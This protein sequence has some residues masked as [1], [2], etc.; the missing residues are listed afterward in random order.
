MSKRTQ[1][2]IV[3]LLIAVLL[4]G[5]AWPLVQE[6]LFQKRVN[7][8]APLLVARPTPVPA[9]DYKV[10]D[11]LHYVSPGGIFYG[12]DLSGK[13]ASRL[14]HVM[15]HTAPDESKPKHSVFTVT[16]REDVLRLL[17]EAWK[18]RGPPKRQGGE[19]G[20][21]I[22]DIPMKRTVGTKGERAIRIIMEVGGPNIV[23]AYPVEI[24]TH[25]R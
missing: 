14:A 13:F 18:R 10:R 12:K 3:G 2:W 6:A 4:L 19:K 8:P 21:D 5:V 7:A 25:A 23:T 11:P 1:E 24:T 9:T 15:A 22:Y 16:K 17:D 20:R